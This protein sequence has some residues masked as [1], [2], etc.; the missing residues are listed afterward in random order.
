MMNRHID[1]ALMLLSQSRH[2]LAEQELRQALSDDPNEAR[3]H[4]LLALC[5]VERDALDD[6][7]SEARMAIHL[8]PDAPFAHYVMAVVLNKRR[9]YR[10]ALAAIDESLRLNPYDADAHALKASVHLQ[11]SRWRDAARSAEEGL[12]VDP[13]H[14]GCTN[15][16]AM[17]L[18][19]LGQR[20]EAGLTID[21]ALARNPENAFSHANQG[22]TLLHAGRPQ[23]AMEHFR[24]ALRIDP[25]LEF[26]RQGIVEAM[27]ARNPVYR[28]LLGYFLWMG[29]LDARVQFALILGL[30]FGQRILRS[31][32][33]QVPALAP[34]APWILGA[35]L[36][37]V[38]I[39]WIAYPLFN[40]LLRLN[41]FGRLALSREQTV[42]SNWLG[43]ALLV[44][45][46]AVLAGVAVSLSRFNEVVGLFTFPG[47]LMLGLSIPVAGTFH[48]EPGWPRTVMALATVAMWL[49]A[50]VCTWLFW[51]VQA[52]DDAETALVWWRAVIWGLVASTWFGSVLGRARPR[53]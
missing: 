23:Q 8:E 49:A 9:H 5:L 24:E 18:V 12:A 26:A 37:F 52:P 6:A 1:R 13:D 39:T 33:E 34:F 48:C 3:A 42:A 15:L 25:Q 28:V 14:V 27:K 11:Q 19:Q 16:R 20:E 29:R 53:R 2:E 47:A 4:A 35:Y 45:F 7:T 38:V 46:A 36:L 31:L 30:V 44:G 32:M 50:F 43:L 17:A 21:A 51:T 41:R 10:E 40:L 22:W